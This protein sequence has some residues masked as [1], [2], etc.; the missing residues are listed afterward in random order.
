MHY[1]FL[2][3]PP[4]F[5]HSPPSLISNCLNLPFGTQGRSRRLNEAYFLQTRNGG[6]GKDLYWR[7]P[8]RVLLS[9]KAIS[10]FWP[11]GYDWLRGTREQKMWCSFITFG[12]SLS[13][14]P[15]WCP[16]AKAPSH[17]PTPL[18]DAEHQRHVHFKRVVRASSQ[19][20]F[21]L[22][23]P[24]PLALFSQIP[25]ST[26]RSTRDGNVSLKSSFPTSPRGSTCQ[27]WSVR[28][29]WKLLGH[30]HFLIMSPDPLCLSLS[31][32][33]SLKYRHKARG[34]AGLKQQFEENHSQGWPSRKTE[35]T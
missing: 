27:L 6:H 35:G 13:W 31:P 19:I 5:L 30:F 24:I 26:H 18:K 3:A 7:G 15:V 2:T 8:H 32:L 16:S 33:Y 4:S 9:F 20:V 28:S 25:R 17:F 11:N 23:K 14:W 21:L 22:I 10:S 34:E 1:C 29:M 12:L